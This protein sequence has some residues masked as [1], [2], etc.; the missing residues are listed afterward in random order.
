MYCFATEEEEEEDETFIVLIKRNL[1]QVEHTLW[2]E[3]R[4]C[5]T[6]G[7]LVCTSG[8]GHSDNAKSRPR[9]S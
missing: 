4:V 2:Q 7:V 3:L 9:H 6:V 5:L 1:K 8:K